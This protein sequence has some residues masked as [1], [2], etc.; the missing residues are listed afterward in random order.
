M[1]LYV[2][3]L[4]WTSA[5]PNDISSIQVLTGATGSLGAH[6]LQNLVSSPSVSKVICLSRAKSHAESLSRV[7][8]SLRIRQR[9]LSAKEQGRIESLAANV[10]EDK[11]GLTEAEYARIQSQATAVIHVSIPFPYSF[12]FAPG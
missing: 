4:I 2:S 10:N 6:V 1:L 11:L 5:S 8:K 7:Q 9:S 12:G 3:S